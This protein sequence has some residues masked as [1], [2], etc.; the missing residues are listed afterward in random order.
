MQFIHEQDV[1]EAQLV[2]L[3]TGSDM[4]MMQVKIETAKM[5]KVAGYPIQ[6]VRLNAFNYRVDVAWEPVIDGQYFYMQLQT[7]YVEHLRA[8]RG[9]IEAVRFPADT[10]TASR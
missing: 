7:R 10:A 6:A 2:R 3:Y 4:R 8:M 5:P 9:M 1:V